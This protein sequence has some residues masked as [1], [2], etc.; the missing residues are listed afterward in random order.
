M[1]PVTLACLWV[2][3]AAA[4]SLLP[5]RR[6]Y[7]PGL[8]L[9]LTAPFLVVW[10]ALTWGPW[11]ALGAT[12]AVISMFRRPLVYLAKRALGRAPARPSAPEETAR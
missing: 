11:M 6:Q 9:L 12:L 1:L 10:L 4:V 3:A 5:M 8:S 7:V 2:L